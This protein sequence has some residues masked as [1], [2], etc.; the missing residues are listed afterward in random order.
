MKNLS[1]LTENP[2]LS[3]LNDA[4][5][6]FR[7]MKTKSPTFMII[8][9]TVGRRRNRRYSPNVRPNWSTGSKFTGLDMGSIMDAVLAMKAQAKT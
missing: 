6:A 2:A 1:T 3:Y 8:A 7:K 5:I 4:E 9:K